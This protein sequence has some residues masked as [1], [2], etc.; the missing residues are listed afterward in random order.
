MSRL[1]EPVPDDDPMRECY[2]MLLRPTELG[3]N[4]ALRYRKYEELAR[5][6]SNGDIQIITN[7]LIM[8]DLISALTT[9]TD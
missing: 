8:L 2:P 7:A 1:V 9:K 3:T 4:L 6:I 5:V